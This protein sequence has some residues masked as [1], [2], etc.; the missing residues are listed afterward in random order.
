MLPEFSES[1][2]INHEFH[3]MK[4]SPDFP[5]YMVLGQDVIKELGINIDFKSQQMGSIR[6]R[7]KS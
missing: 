3:V 2:I 7:K 4:G 5:Y 6:S 1:K